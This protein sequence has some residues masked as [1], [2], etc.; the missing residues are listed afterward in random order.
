[1]LVCEGSWGT[2]SHSSPLSGDSIIRRGNV[3]TYGLRLV[4]WNIYWTYT[5]R[6]ALEAS[7]PWIH[8][9][10]TVATLQPFPTFSLPSRF[11]PAG[12]DSGPPCLHLH[13]LADICLSELSDDLAVVWVMASSI[14]VLP[15]VSLG[16]PSDRFSHL[17]A[18]KGEP[19]LRA[20][21]PAAVRCPS[22]SPEGPRFL[23]STSCWEDRSRRFCSTCTPPL[24]LT[25]SLNY[26][27]TQCS[28]THLISR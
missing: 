12:G 14:P 22:L 1:M 23:H 4:I 11:F 21:V 9:L 26:H 27:L 15:T 13:L 6:Q 28:P 16:C 19:S 2:I 24:P 20:N 3:D 18:H 5:K 7:F 10:S 17:P 8:L 25:S